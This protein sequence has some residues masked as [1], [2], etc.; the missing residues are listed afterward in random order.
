[1]SHSAITQ[2][3]SKDFSELKEL[4]DRANQ[5]SIK[6]AGVRLW[7]M[8]DYVYEQF[9]LQLERGECHV[10]RDESGHITSMIAFNED[11][12]QW[13]DDNNDGRALYFYKW[14]KDPAGA[15]PDEPLELLKFALQAAQKRHKTLIRCDTVS[16]LTGLIEYYKKLGFKEVKS[17]VYASSGR[18]GV[19]LEATVE[20]VLSHLEVQER[21]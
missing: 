7:T 15:E 9:R 2:A 13:G 16:E 17:F 8:M 19:L 11:V 3:N 1:M 6:R 4:L 12:G 18:P 21:A 20:S 10:I 14:M 5:Y